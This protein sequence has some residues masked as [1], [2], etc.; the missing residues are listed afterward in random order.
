MD[1]NNPETVAETIDAIF[2]AGA[3][4]ATFT[5]DE[6]AVARQ[7]H[8]YEPPAPGRHYRLKVSRSGHVSPTHPQ[9]PL[10]KHNGVRTVQ[11]N[12]VPPSV[13]LADV[14]RL[15]SGTLDL[16]DSVMWEFGQIGVGRILR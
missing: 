5:V 3:A 2:G 14:I 11:I 15:Y 1:N 8:F 6:L 12:S 16:S 4:E 9:A 10:G 13:S 7:P